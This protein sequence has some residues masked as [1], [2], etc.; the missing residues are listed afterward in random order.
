[1]QQPTDS[2][3]EPEPGTDGAPPRATVVATLA[4][5][6]PAGPG[7]RRELL[8]GVRRRAEVL[9]VRADAV[10]DLDPAELRE[11]FAGRLL[12]TLRS[13]GEGGGWDGSD[14]RRRERLARAAE[15]YDFVDL[16]AE[17]DAVPEVLERIP[18]E[19][20][21][22]SWHGPPGELV[23]L[24]ER[25]AR[26]AA[27]PARLYKM[28]VLASRPGEEVGVVDLAGAMRRD[29]LLAFAAGRGA[30]WTRLVAPRLG[31]RLVYGAAVPGA[32][33]A[34]GQLT[35]EELA[36][37]FGLPDLPPVE[38]LFG[39]AGERVLG[40][41]LSPRLHN[42]AYRVLG[43]SAAYLPFETDSFGDFWLEVVESGIFDRIGMPLG[44]LSVTAPHKRAALAVAGA[45]SPLA[46][47]VGAA[48]TLTCT[49]GVWEAE[50]T[51]ARGVLGPLEARGIAV[52]GR[53]AAV[54]GCGGAGRAAAFGLARAGAEVTL[55]NRGEE[56]GREA[57][58]RLG[59][60]FV[61]LAAFR[62][63]EHDL[64][65][66]A[67]SLGRSDDDPPAFAVDELP[68][69]AAVVDLVYREA[70][71][72]PLV[73]AARARGLAAVEGR[74]V[75]LH[76]AIDQLRA[77]TGRELPAA[78]GARLLGLGGEEAVAPEAGV[79]DEGAGG[80]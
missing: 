28:V 80:R 52:A 51:D 57:S 69:G 65:I 71:P 60:P 75:L 36:R 2:Q 27:V 14:D 13:R 42:G 25:F 63:A 78:L 1:M 56:R 4:G 19:R 12:Y 49:G 17:R 79:R 6:L 58:E 32:G 5:S 3:S 21:I 64:V 7:A 34:A 22:V 55:V 50:S 45:A 77:M 15:T 20:R 11:G 44:G 59:L 37:D 10:G 76:Q 39:I 72:T 35:V 9:E 40:A 43:I 26:L 54:V 8:A 31:A 70:G 62:P 41:S 33:G 46:E 30:A 16:E 74:E 61:P 38:R 66:Q 48:N 23:E 24:E 47:C 68:A 18:A 67:T 73:A 29:D 53:T